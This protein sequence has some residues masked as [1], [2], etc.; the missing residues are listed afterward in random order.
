MSR[1]A[2]PERCPDCRTTMPYGAAACSHCGLSLQGPLAAELFTTLS[3][4][5]QLLARLRTETAPATGPAAPGDPR[6]EGGLPAA[7]DSDGT[8]TRALVRHRLSAASVP[9]ILL[10]L[11]AVCL[12]VAALVFIAVTWSAM[13]IGGRTATLVGFTAVAGALTA[14]CARRGLRTGAEALAVVTLGLLGFDLVGAQDAG[15]LGPLGLDGFLVVAGLALLA[16]GAATTLASAGTPAGALVAPEVVAALGTAAA[17]GGTLDSGWLPWSPLLVV[18]LTGSAAVV[19][20]G[21]LAGLRVLAAGAALVAGTGWLLLVGSSAERALAHPSLVELWR[22]GEIWP[23]LVAAASVAALGLPKALP[24]A[25]RRAA[26]GIGV[27]VGTGASLVPVSD[28]TVTE[29]VLAVAAATAVLAVLCRLLTPAWRVVVTGALALGVVAAAVA[30]ASLLMR[31]TGNLAHAGA[32]L[33]SGELSGSL[34]SEAPATEGLAGLA[35]WTLPVLVAT[36]VLVAVALA[37]SFPAAD[38]VLAPLA[39]P[40]VVG[41]VAAG[42]GV[43]TLALYAVPVALVVLLLTGL[44]AGF[45]MVALSTDRPLPLALG[46]L[47][48]TP[49]LVTSLYAEWL[50]LLVLASIAVLAL[51]VHVRWVFLEMAAVAGTVAAG[52]LGGLMWT[53]GAVVD[54]PAAWTALWSLL[55]LSALVLGLPYAERAGVLSRRHAPAGPARLGPDLGSLAAAAGLGLAGV[56]GAPDGDR[57]A[58]LAVYLTVAGATCAALA[59]LRPERR[60]AGWLGGLLLAMATWVRLAD[61]GV[62]APEAYTLPTA[63]ALLGV[64]LHRLRRAEGA[65]SLAVLT[66]GL[67]LALVPSLLWVLVDP[68]TIRSALLGVACLGLV[69]AGAQLRWSGPLLHGAGVGL[70]LALRHATPIADAVPRWALFATAGVLLVVMGI[71]WEQ[72]LREARAVTGYVREMR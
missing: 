5:D 32:Q 16:A 55:A 44:G 17:V 6:T 23:L 3:R 9:Q 21:H 72:R 64:G 58:W 52:A 27:V 38:R 36:V 54:A 26:V 66:P 50:T 48:T 40:R 7:G 29:G 63:L 35:P 10:G 33:W 19:A 69:V 11:G 60:P 45:A 18:A 62:D 46:A 56:L 61:L 2:D 8:S 42:T 57:S 34:S 68:L 43:A 25:A 70:L 65:G 31:A 67:S 51:A 41:A 20:V 71:T 12:L 28:E 1:Y 22:D 49:A 4:A 15:W 53:V 14:W 30:A 13:G 47:F 24:P 37:R 39:D 59:L